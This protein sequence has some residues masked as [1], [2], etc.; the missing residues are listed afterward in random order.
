MSLIWLKKWHVNVYLMPS[1]L[2]SAG[3]RTNSSTGNTKLISHQQEGSEDAGRQSPHLKTHRDHR[4]LTQHKH[5]TLFGLSVRSWSRKIF[6]HH[7]ERKPSPQTLK[8]KTRS[9]QFV[10][11]NEAQIKSRHVSWVHAVIYL[12]LNKTEDSIK[13][14]N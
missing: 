10:S 14:R 1:L 12:G 9:S 13:S 11:E 5:W 7:Q 4:K 8:Q 3:N 2:A 6:F